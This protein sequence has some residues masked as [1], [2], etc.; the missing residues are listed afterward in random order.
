M[1]PSQQEK[2]AAGRDHVFNALKH[3]EHHLHCGVV[4]RG[5]GGWKGEGRGGESKCR[6]GQKVGEESCSDLA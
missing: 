3:P 2:E 5:R 6:P 1:R 4:G